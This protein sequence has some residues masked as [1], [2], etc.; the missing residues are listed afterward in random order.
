MFNS[1]QVTYRSTSP[2]FTPPST[3]VTPFSHTPTS[4]CSHSPPPT[5][6]KDL[7]PHLQATQS[8]PQLF[9]PVMSISAKAFGKQPAPF[10]TDLH[11]QE[12]IPSSTSGINPTPAHYGQVTDTHLFDAAENVIPTISSSQPP[13]PW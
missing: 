13:P 5:F 4:M 7:P 8:P 6:Q 3:P 9:Y 2:S 12:A 11:Y 10:D 1:P